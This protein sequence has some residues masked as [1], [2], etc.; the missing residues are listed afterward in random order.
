M[1]DLPLTYNYCRICGD[2][3]HNTFDRMNIGPIRFWSPDDG[4]II[5]SLCPYCYDECG[6]CKP[7]P[8]DYAYDRLNNVC[9]DYDTDEEWVIE[10]ER[11]LK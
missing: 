4:W 5:G 11:I 9:D 1:S 8:D 3:P 6:Q 7:K 10:Y 2:Q